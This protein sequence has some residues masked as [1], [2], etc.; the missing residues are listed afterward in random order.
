[1]T[2]LPQP[3]PSSAAEQAPRGTFTFDVDELLGN[4]PLWVLDVG[5]RVR[6]SAALAHEVVHIGLV[7]GAGKTSSLRILSNALSSAHGLRHGESEDVA[8]AL[9]RDWYRRLGI[10]PDLDSWNENF[11]ERESH[12]LVRCDESLTVEVGNLFRVNSELTLGTKESARRHVWTRPA[13]P[14]VDRE[15]L[16]DKI[17]QAILRCLGWWEAA[18]AVA[19]PEASAPQRT[20]DSGL[21]SVLSS[22]LARE[23]FEEIGPAFPPRP[24]HRGPH[25]ARIARQLALPIPFLR[26]DSRRR[27]ATAVSPSPSPSVGAARSRWC[28]GAAD[29]CG[30]SHPDHRR[31]GLEA[32]PRR[33]R[34][35]GPPAAGVAGGGGRCRLPVQKVLR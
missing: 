16:L 31:C 3:P 33:S 28:R 8:G 4:A 13:T 35:I 25:D 14:T 29:S 5:T 22:R 12:T 2:A 1:M 30:G 17:W 11:E 24:P 34:I 10:L 19:I 15:Q 23:G 18:H 27:A 20:S 26:P 21:R 9:H 6:L 7:V 32:G